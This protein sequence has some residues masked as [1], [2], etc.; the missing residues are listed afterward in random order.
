MI[1]IAL[2]L[3]QPGRFTTSWITAES[4]GVRWLGPASP[5]RFH[6]AGVQVAEAAV[7]A[8]VETL[9]V[10]ENVAGLSAA[11]AATRFVGLFWILVGLELD[12]GPADWRAAR[13]RD[14]GEAQADPLIRV[15]VE[16]QL[17]VGAGELH[18]A[19]GAFLGVVGAGGDAPVHGGD[20]DGRARP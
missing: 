4:S 8:R 13:N 12:V 2:P 9:L 11:S 20:G 19:G 3:A 16:H 5:I 15:D 17:D 1:T 18:A 10:K 6:P 7:R 14:V